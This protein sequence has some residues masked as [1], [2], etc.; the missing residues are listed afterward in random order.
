MRSR[1]RP[2]P[3]S[4]GSTVIESETMKTN[5]LLDEVMTKVQTLIELAD[6]NAD[7]L[8]KPT[9]AIRRRTTAA[10]ARRSAKFNS[11]WRIADDDTST[12]QTGTLRSKRAALLDDR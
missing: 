5:Q 1:A 8:S 9:P 10:G 12:D 11:Y 2:P 7:L 6:A 4:N 3:S